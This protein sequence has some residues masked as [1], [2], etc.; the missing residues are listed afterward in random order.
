MEHP[1][2]T[3]GFS[4]WLLMVPLALTSTTGIGPSPRRHSAGGGSTSWCIS[5][6]PAASSTSSGSSR[7]T[8]PPR[9]GSGWCWCC[10]SD[11]AL[12]PG[13]PPRRAGR[14]AP[15]SREA[16]PRPLIRLL[17]SIR[18]PRYLPPSMPSRSPLL[19]ERAI[20]RTLTRM[21]V[22]IVEQ[23]HGTEDLLLVGIQR[24]GVHLAERLAPLI[25]TARRRRGAARQARHH[26]LSR[27]PPG[28]R[29]P[30]RGGRDQPPR[31]PR[32]PH[33][34]HRRRRALHRAHRPRRPRR[35]RRLRPAHAGSCSACW[36]TAAAGS[37]RSRPTSPGQTVRRRRRA[38]GWTCS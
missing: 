37:C 14:P 12:A 16:G 26:A 31:L 13:P 30:A 25:E 19:D 33:R 35:V 36:S 17:D 21:A 10:C 18:P 6:R 32:R 11:P 4:A 28:H 1:W 29:P 27:R 34:R 24:R 15:R 3:A 23:C 20:A 5:R 9:R 8:S 2:V 22:E 7:R 38:T